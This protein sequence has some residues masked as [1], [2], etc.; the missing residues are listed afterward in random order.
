M[1]KCDRIER[2]QTL[3]KGVL[4][5]NHMQMQD[6]VAYTDPDEDDDNPSPESLCKVGGFAFGLLG[7]VGWGCLHGDAHCTQNKLEYFSKLHGYT[8]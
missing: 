3:L 7:E 6:L 1:L 5:M 4:E 8:A 2:F